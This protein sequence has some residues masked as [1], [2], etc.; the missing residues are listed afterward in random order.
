MG[1]S[2]SWIGVQAMTADELH[3]KLGLSETE[4]SGKYFDFS[5]AG[6]MLPNNWYLLTAERCDHPIISDQVLIELSAMTSI[7]SCS[8]EEHVMYMSSALW[9][10]GREIWRVQHRGGDQGI[11]DLSVRGSPPEAFEDLRAR[12][13]ARQAAAGGASADVDHIAD[14]PLE[15]A[16][17]T[18]GFKHDEITPGIDNTSF[19]ALRVAPSGLLTEATRPW[20]KFW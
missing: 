18:V 6:L 7:V 13:F 8:I 4:A 3:A 10:G 11:M 9:R 20:W 19:R 12:Y 2:M 14:I 5:I 16:R 17:S 15:L 1:V